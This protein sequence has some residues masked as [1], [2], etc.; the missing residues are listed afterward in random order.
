M[1]DLREGRRILYSDSIQAA[2]RG[3]QLLEGHG[4]DVRQP[5]E[6]G[7]ERKNV[8]QIRKLEEAHTRGLTT[9]VN[10]YSI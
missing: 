7:H 8:R 9:I 10:K 3:A 4:R 2:G 5:Q 6:R 1:A